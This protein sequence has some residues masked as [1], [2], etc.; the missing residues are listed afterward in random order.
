MTVG[1]SLSVDY[2]FQVKWQ[3]VTSYS[4]VTSSGYGGLAGLY[5]D[6]NAYIMEGLTVKEVND[7][8]GRREGVR[9]R[10]KELE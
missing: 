1:G 8:Q 3:G 7:C 4:R 10:S 6:K 2:N 5:A 9:V